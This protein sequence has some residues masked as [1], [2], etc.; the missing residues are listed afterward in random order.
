MIWIN[1]HPWQV[2]NVL[3]QH[4]LLSVSNSYLI[5]AKLI[6]GHVRLE[7]YV[8]FDLNEVVLCRLVRLSA[9]YQANLAFG[10]DDD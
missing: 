3:S 6:N 1:K 5:F 10:S 8:L 9:R 2:V 7:Q 4:T